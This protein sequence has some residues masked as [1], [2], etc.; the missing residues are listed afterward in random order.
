MV[1]HLFGRLSLE[2][3]LSLTPYFFNVSFSIFLP[4]TLRSHNG[5][6]PLDFLT[7][8]VQS[9]L[10]YT[11]RATCPSILIDLIN[12]SLIIFVKYHNL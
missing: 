6:F 10:I 4:S 8:M 2:S 5:L 11:M 12:V 3:I 7:R 1:T 9:F